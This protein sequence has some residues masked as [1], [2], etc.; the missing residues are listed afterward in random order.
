[1]KSKFYVEF[2]NGDLSGNGFIENMYTISEIDYD[3]F[4]N[5][6]NDYT[7]ED[8]E[9]FKF[10]KKHFGDI[11]IMTPRTSFYEKIKNL[12]I[13]SDKFKQLCYVELLQNEIF[14][15]K[16]IDM[17]INKFEEEESE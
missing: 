15:I 8:D 1:M 3:Y 13:N 6:I 4:N 5:L 12:D 16:V 17:N 9:Y 7:K 11:I 14:G 10:V 2:V